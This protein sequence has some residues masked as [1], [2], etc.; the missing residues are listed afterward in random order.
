MATLGW[1]RGTSWR[2][3]HL[4]DQAVLGHPVALRYSDSGSDSR[5]FRQ[6]S[7]MSRA[8]SS[9]G[10]S[11]RRSRNWRARSR[12]SAWMS[13]AR[14]SRP[15][16]RR[17][18]RWQVMSWLI[19]R[20]A[21]MGFSRVRSRSTVLES[22]SMASRML[23]VPTFKK[24]AYSLM[25]ESPTITCRRRKR[26]A[27]AWGSS[28][29]LMIGRL[30]VVADDT[31][32]P[33][34]LGPLADAVDGAPGGLEHL[35]GTG[36]DLAA[37][38]ERDEDLGVA[39][40]VVVALG[41]VVLVAA[42][43]VAGRVGVVLE[44]VDVAADALLAEPGLGPGRPAGRGSTP[45]PCRGSPG[46]R[47]VALGGGVLGVAADVEVEA[48]PVLQEDVGGAAPADHPAEEVAGD[49]VGAQPAL[50]AERER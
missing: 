32:F 46:R 22:S 14:I 33:D 37:D 38:Q 16:A 49:L 10:E 39:V 21:R 35:A 15:L 5:P 13:R 50:A 36:E 12:Y 48:G 17:T 29:V 45:P 3:P 2:S 1:A 23:V 7:H 4:F 30:R 42:V 25:L 20:M 34:V 19:S 24:V 11:P 27:S 28:R 40:E 8:R 26:S 6:C 41:Q 9:S 18:R 44:Q 47:W 31:P 43:G